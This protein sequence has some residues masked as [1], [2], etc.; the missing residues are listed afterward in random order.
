VKLRTRPLRRVAIV[1][2]ALLAFFAGMYGSPTFRHITVGVL[3][4]VVA[5]YVCGMVLATIKTKLDGPMRGYSKLAASGVVAAATAG[6]PSWAIGG[7]V[8]LAAALVTTLGVAIFVVARLAWN[9]YELD[10]LKAELEAG[11]DADAR[12]ARLSRL[13]TWAIAPVVDIL[14]AYQRPDVVDRILATGQHSALGLQETW[15]HTSALLA[16]HRVDDARHRLTASSPSGKL[17]QQAVMLLDARV[18][19]AEGS[20]PATVIARLNAE[21]VDTSLEPWRIEVLADAHA[22]CG[23]REQAQK[24]LQD[25]LAK[26]ERSW[27]A[28][29][30]RSS[31]PSAEIAKQVLDGAATPYR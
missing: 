9:R 24:H 6:V 19:L 16:L 29:L 1:W 23:D 8:S 30:A 15:Y 13:G 22:T 5:L 28:A 21:T 12:I 14:L 18:S 20:D 4:G 25:F 2:I 7:A 17:F 26:S 27:L 31:R 11:A 10:K 3:F